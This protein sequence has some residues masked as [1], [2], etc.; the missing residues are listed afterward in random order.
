MAWELN[1]LGV[2]CKLEKCIETLSNTEE[3]TEEMRVRIETL[4]EVDKW[5]CGYENTLGLENG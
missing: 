1:G 3:M 2:H 4:K 5:I